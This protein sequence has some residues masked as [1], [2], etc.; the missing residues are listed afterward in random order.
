MGGYY[1]RG[2]S[3]E[4]PSPKEM[5]T[6]EVN[7][8]I[9]ILHSAIDNEKL[10]DTKS[11]LS[12]LK[13]AI[14]SS[15]PLY[16]Q[17]SAPFT[18]YTYAVLNKKKKVASSL[19]KTILKKNYEFDG[20]P[21]F[22]LITNMTQHQFRIILADYLKDPS[23][24]WFL[25]GLNT[26]RLM[27]EEYPK[28]TDEFIIQG[29]L[30]KFEKG[31]IRTETAAL[32]CSKAKNKDA[33]IAALTT[34]FDLN[35]A[36]QYGMHKNKLLMIREA[37]NDQPKD[38]IRYVLSDFFYIIYLKDIDP[39]MFEKDFAFGY[40]D[41]RVVENFTIMKFRISNHGLV[42]TIKQLDNEILKTKMVTVNSEIQNFVL[43]TNPELLPQEVKDIFLF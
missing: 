10:K 11:A 35:Y 39:K 21:L 29:K 17:A 9:D 40:L 37:L 12:K 28:E 25:E 30:N 38:I 6:A 31:D 4:T 7:E 2:Y 36:A 18:A 19:L 34:F 26:I 33:I 20:M 1:G 22:T 5:D 41:D 14:D 16:T 43:E 24:K 13:L 32:V 23:S 8:L 3:Y 27:Y 42:E 15:N